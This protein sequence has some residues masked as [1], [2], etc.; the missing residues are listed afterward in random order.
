MRFYLTR[1]SIHNINTQC[2]QLIN[3]TRVVRHQAN[4]FNA[5]FLQD[6]PHRRVFSTIV[7]KAKCSVGIHG[8]KTLFLQ[9]VGCDFVG[10]T[11]AAAF[12]LEVDDHARGGVGNVVKGQLELFSAVAF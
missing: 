1:H 8:V 4:G 12:L 10:Q 2:S 3:L 11:D 6:V 7:W 5:Q 9:G